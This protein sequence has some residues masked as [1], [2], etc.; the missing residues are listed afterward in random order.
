ML[1]N[2]DFANLL[3][4]GDGNTTTTNDDTNTND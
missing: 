2:S 4:S 3:S 1:S